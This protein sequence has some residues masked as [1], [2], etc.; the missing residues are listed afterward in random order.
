MGA[1]SG[2]AREVHGPRLLGVL[3]VVLL[4]NQ[5]VRGVFVR[6]A[7]HLAAQLLL[8]GAD[9]PTLLNRV[10]HHLLFFKALAGV[11]AV[12]AQVALLAHVDEV[13]H[14]E[15]KAHQRR[16]RQHD[17]NVGPLLHPLREV[18]AFLALREGR[19]APHNAFLLQLACGLLHELNGLLLTDLALVRG[20]VPFGV[21]VLRLQHSDGGDAV[22]TFGRLGN[23]HSRIVRRAVARFVALPGLTGAIMGR[24]LGQ[25][26][27]DILA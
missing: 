4:L 7:F 9:L 3:L 21:K 10:G 12:Q 22:F 27:G 1:L 6:E 24:D 16:D 5:V 8:T 23:A 11:V 15:V 13:L 26:N 25:N 2:P 19:L 18:G 17:E 20:L 14:E